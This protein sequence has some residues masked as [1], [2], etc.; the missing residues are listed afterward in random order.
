MASVYVR[1]YKDQ[2]EI[3]KTGCFEFAKRRN[4]RAPLSL[5]AWVPSYDSY[6]NEFYPFRSCA[7]TGKFFYESQIQ[8]HLSSKKRVLSCLPSSNSH[9]SS[10]SLGI[11]S[12]S[13][14]HT[15][16][17]DHG[18][19]LPSAVDEGMVIKRLTDLPIT[20]CLTWMWMPNAFKQGVAGRFTKSIL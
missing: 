5:K 19:P 9:Y 7:S 16:Y 20:Q 6:V 10:L 11:H 2:S 12:D 1:L 17:L 4:V 3:S 13:W 8:S 18:I 14:I 15:F